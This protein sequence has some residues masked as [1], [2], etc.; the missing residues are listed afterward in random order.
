MIHDMSDDYAVIQ[1]DIAF[2]HYFGISLIASL[3]RARDLG[4][5]MGMTK[6]TTLGKLGG[7][8]YCVAHSNHLHTSRWAL[9]SISHA[10]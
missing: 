6:G 1:L 10:L 4:D 3:E 7:Q 5:H 8:N 2:T 9:L